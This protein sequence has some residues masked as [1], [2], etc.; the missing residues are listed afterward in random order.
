MVRI[1]LFKTLIK[2]KKPKNNKCLYVY[3]NELRNDNTAWK[4][5]ARKFLK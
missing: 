5:V 2:Y 4:T 1:R 3:F